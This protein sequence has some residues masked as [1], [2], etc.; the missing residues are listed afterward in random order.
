LPVFQSAQ[1]LSVL[2][3]SSD[4]LIVD[5]LLQ[6]V[7]SL[8]AGNARRDSSDMDTAPVGGGPQAV[9]KSTFFPLFYFG[10]FSPANPFCMF[11]Y[12][13]LLLIMLS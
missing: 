5:G 10:V 11:P 9:E 8:E 7:E 1:H 2:D 3:D 4:A 12:F 6:Q 13:V